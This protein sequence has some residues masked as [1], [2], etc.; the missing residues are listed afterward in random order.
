MSE[1]S[2]K[3]NRRRSRTPCLDENRVEDESCADN[4]K[5]IELS[6]ISDDDEQWPECNNKSDE[7]TNGNP[8]SNANGDHRHHQPHQKGSAFKKITRS[9][10][11]RNYRDNVKKRDFGENHNEFQQSRSNYKSKIDNSRR[12]EIERYNVRKVVASRD[13]SISRSRSRSATPR[14]SKIPRHREY[15]SPKRDAHHQRRR[16]ISPVAEATNRQ[17]TRY[18]PISISPPS[19]ISS[20]S[21]DRF[22][23][24][25]QHQY[26][27]RSKSPSFGEEEEVVVRRSRSRHKHSEF[28]SLKIHA[29]SFR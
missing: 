29:I 22:R 13:F 11:D 20:L 2:E 25:Q 17:K 24:K 1:E 26:S 10:R 28:D 12:K 21:P 8:K 4:S 27:K 18:S 7:C 16:S 23:S 5:E 6:D 19:R 15:F 14:R 3:L 9:N